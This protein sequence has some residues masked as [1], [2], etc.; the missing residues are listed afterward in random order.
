MDNT[1]NTNKERGE[2]VKQ[3]YTVDCKGM[4]CKYCFEPTVKLCEFTG[5]KKQVQRHIKKNWKQP[6]VKKVKK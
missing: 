3:K 2:E 1:S 5:T 6:K 4:S